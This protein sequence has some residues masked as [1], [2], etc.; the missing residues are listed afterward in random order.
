MIDDLRKPILVERKSD[1]IYWITLKLGRDYRKSTRGVDEEGN[2]RF[3]NFGKDEED[4]V[5][6]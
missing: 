6:Q 5:L 2:D 1:C 4:E 3:L